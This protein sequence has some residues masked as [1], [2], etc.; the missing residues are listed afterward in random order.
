MA[1]FMT[2]IVRLI[3]HEGG[4]AAQDNGRGAVNFG[5][6]QKT[7]DEL[8]WATRKGWPLTVKDLKRPQAE[9]FYYEEFWCKSRANKIDNESLASLLFELS[10]NC[11]LGR[12]ARWLQEAVGTT[13]DGIV[14]VQTML[15]VNSQSSAVTIAN[16]KGLA[17]EHYQG[18]AKSK[19]QIYGD[20]LAGWMDRL[21]EMTGDNSIRVDKA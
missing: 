9:E 12:A 10:V 4:Y 2:A 1:N 5:I 20:D 17:W 21:A 6:T 7:Y 15:N 3:K 14:G 13:V 8:G 11:G 19:P 16:L 18:L